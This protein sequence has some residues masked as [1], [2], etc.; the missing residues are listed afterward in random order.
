M[1]KQ[2]AVRNYFLE[3]SFTDFSASYKKKKEDAELTDKSVF[4]KAFLH[5][6]YGFYF[7]GLICCFL[8]VHI[9]FLILLF[10]DSI[11]R[12]KNK[13]FFACSHCYHKSTSPI[14]LCPSCGVEHD[15]LRPSQYGVMK[16][17]CQCGEEIPTSFFNGRSKL[18]AIC[19]NCKRGMKS[20]ESRPIIIPIIGGQSSGKSHFLYSMIYYI[21]EQFSKSSEY[22]FEF[23][24]GKS[25]EA[26]YNKQ[27]SQIN[28]GVGANKTTDKEPVASNFFLKKKNSKTLFY[29]YDSAGEAFIDE[30]DMHRQKYFNY[31]DAII[32]IIDVFSI[33]EIKNKYKDD[34]NRNGSIKPSDVSPNDT[35]EIFLI[36]LRKNFG[37]K[38]TQKINKPL[39]VLLTK[40]DAFDINKYLGKNAMIDYK[41]KNMNL[42]KNEIRNDVCEDFL[43][44]NGLESFTRK[45]KFN[46]SDYTYFPISAMGNKS[47]GIDNATKWIL[48]KT[49]KI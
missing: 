24:Q 15:N 48:K 37:F 8:G 10:I 21:K 19:P 38:P 13:I 31:V 39:I 2:P 36:N 33:P 12:F 4:Y 45:I 41:A 43:N 9:G 28:S 49:A 29:F 7:I 3:K 40:I 35:N 30:K 25:D 11:Y 18:E 32:L 47:Y 27:I 22:R 6:G 44:K 16:R 5:I 17:T 14:Y 42:N 23:L 34:L 46:F 1:K 26:V 20:E